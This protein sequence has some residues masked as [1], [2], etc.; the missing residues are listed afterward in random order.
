MSSVNGVAV[1]DRLGAVREL[2]RQ[3]AVALGLVSADA[4][5]QSLDDAIEALLDREIKTPEPSEDECRR[6]YAQNQADFTAGELVFARHILFAVTP[7]VPVGPLRS[8]AEQTLDELCRHPERF[9]DRARE[10]SNC[11]SGRHDG[12]LGQLSRGEC[13]PEFEQAIFG[14]A[15]TGLR[16][17]LVNT[18]YGFHII[19]IDGRV[20]GQLV[21]FE[22]VHE[23]IAAHL[24]EQVGRKAL[25][26]Y[27]AVLAGKADVQGV[28]LNA[29]ASPLI[30]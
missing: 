16:R 3:R 24:A 25:A 13:A 19:A 8:K 22:A 28:D 4:N 26:Q 21:P 10:L 5:N 27:V 7:G 12:N 11:P 29:A 1:T 15:A 17:R 6:F 14:M 2:L 9:A 30:Q 20:A 23:K 18:R